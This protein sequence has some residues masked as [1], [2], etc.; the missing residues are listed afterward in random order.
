MQKTVIKRQESRRVNAL[1][2]YAIIQS[3][4][5]ERY[6]VGNQ[7]KSKA[8]AY[9]QH[10]NNLYPMGERTFWRIMG[11]NVQQEIEKVNHGQMSLNFVS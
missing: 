7:S 10:I 8:Q 9:R 11:T 6:E 4:V 2:R 1:K 3:L 5:A